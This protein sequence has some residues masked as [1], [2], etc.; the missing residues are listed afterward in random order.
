MGNA[1]Y[2]CIGDIQFVRAQEDI[3]AGT[4][5]FM[6]YLPD[7]EYL[8]RRRFLVE[9]L[10]GEMLTCP[11][12]MCNDDALDGRPGVDDRGTFWMAF[13]KIL[14]AGDG[15]LLGSLPYAENHLRVCKN[16]VK[17]RSDYYD[18]RR[19]SGIKFELFQLYS[20]MVLSWIAI[21]NLMGES[22]QSYNYFF[23][24]LLLSDLS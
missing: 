20:R 18:N 16:H 12:L 15:L 9:R 1:T 11:C 8:H 3:P 14:E 10:G 22:I 7:K 21:G 4:Q 23:I 2:R 13:E 6:S 24:S 17:A 5:I 19:V